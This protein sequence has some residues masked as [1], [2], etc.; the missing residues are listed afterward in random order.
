MD[1]KL[2]INKMP[3]YYMIKAR[4]INEIPESYL[5]FVGIFFPNFEVGELFPCPR[6]IRP[7]PHY[8]MKVD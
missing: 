6:L 5:I 7:W 4:K 2:K 8:F 1:E 3:D